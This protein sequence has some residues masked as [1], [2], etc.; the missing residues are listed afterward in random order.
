ME[1]VKTK[2]TAE[3]VF[4]VFSSGALAGYGNQDF[5]DVKVDDGYIDALKEI[6]KEAF[7]QQADNQW[8]VELTFNRVFLVA[9]KE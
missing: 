3:E 7:V 6:V 9:A 8:E 2:H 5:Y 1:S 4:D